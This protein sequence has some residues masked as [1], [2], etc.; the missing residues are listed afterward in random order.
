M[1]T[2]HCVACGSSINRDGYDRAANPGGRALEHVIPAWVQSH[3]RIDGRVVAHVHQ[4]WVE[5]ERCIADKSPARY[6]V[7]DRAVHGRV[8]GPC[9]NGWMGRLEQAVSPFLRSLIDGQT[10]LSELASEQRAIL[11]KWILKTAF[12]VCDASAWPGMVPVDHLR[13][14]MQGQLPEGVALFGASNPTAGIFGSHMDRQW[15]VQALAM[16]PRELQRR[17]A[18]IAG[19]SYKFSIM[20]GRIM[21]LLIYF[22]PAGNWNLAVTPDIHEEIWPRTQPRVAIPWSF[23]FPVSPQVLLMFHFSVG[24]TE[25]AV[26]DASVEVLNGTRQ[27][28]RH[29]SEF[30]RLVDLHS[31]NCVPY[32]EP[33]HALDAT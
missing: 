31:A 25:R 10:R 28:F 21:L 27:A 4:G 30:R 13:F 23:P 5:R 26:W 17:V 32:I 1:G 33:D 9:N 6:P 22:P 20:L 16:G 8:C 2:K 24:L 3:L 29:E 19:A 15:M 14:V 18:E 12:F 11:V 7:L